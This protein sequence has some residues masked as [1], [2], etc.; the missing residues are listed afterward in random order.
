MLDF[1]DSVAPDNKR[2]ARNVVNQTLGYLDFRGKLLAVRVNPVGSE[3]F[4]EDVRTAAAFERVDALVVPKV[5]SGDAVRQV[6]ALLKTLRRRLSIEV[7]IESAAGVMHAGEIASA[8]GAVAALHFGPFDFAASLGAPTT[9]SRIPE[10]IHLHGLMS[11]LVAGRAFGCSVVDGPFAD[12][13]DV[14]GLKLAAGR[15]ARIGCDGKWAIHPTQI[16]I[17]NAAFTPSADDMRRASAILD[18][19]AEGVGNG[20]GAISLNGEMVDEATRRWAEA[21]ISRRHAADPS[22]T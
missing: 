19:F 20:R 1:E 6:D 15:A 11:I 2:A 9:G 10:E 4:E 12:I 7:Q 14:E 3:W 18:A 22:E 5:E 17:I 16:D 13:N 8:S 21:T